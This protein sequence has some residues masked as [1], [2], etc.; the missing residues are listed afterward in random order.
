VRRAAAWG[1]V[2]LYV[3]VFPA[4][5]NMA[6]HHISLDDAHP[7]PP[8]AL[9]LRLPIQA[10]LVAMAYWMSRPDPPARER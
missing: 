5:V 7:I 6:V 9:W 8:L 10:L 1:L 4:N 2:A 3:A